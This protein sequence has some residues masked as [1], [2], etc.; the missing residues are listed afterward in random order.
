M[1]GP[2]S[3]NEVIVRIP[4]DVCSNLIRA[5]KSLAKALLPLLIVVAVGGSPL[6]KPEEK[7]EDQDVKPEYIGVKKYH[8]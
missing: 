4:G 2:K 5:C 8:Q 1:P 3:K 7:F 6:G